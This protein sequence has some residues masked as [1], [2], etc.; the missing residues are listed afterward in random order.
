MN[1]KELFPLQVEQPEAKSL[2]NILS[3]YLR[4]WYLFAFGIAL[5]LG[6]AFAYLRYYAIPRYQ[7]T[8][9]VL[10]KDDD[11]GGTAMSSGAI[12]L[13]VFRSSKNLNNEIE[14]LKS[15]DLMHRVVKELDLGTTYYVE[16][17]FRN[18][19]L[20]NS[21]NPIRTIVS[22]LDTNI[23]NKDIYLV[24]KSNIEYQLFDNNDEQGITYRFGQ[25]IH[26]PYGSF[27]IVANNNTLLKEYLNKKIII[28]LHDTRDVAENFSSGLTVSPIKEDATVLRIGI[29]D[30]IPSRGV[31]IVNKLVQVYNKE[32]LE[33]R[34]I[35][36]TNTIAFLDD[37][38]KYITGEL[39]DV[40]KS[41]AQYK[42]S[43]ELTDVTTQA[44]NYVEQASDYNKRLSDW[45][46]QIDI[47]ESI[48]SYLKQNKGQYKMVP[49]TLGIQDETLLGLI[50]KFN[51][52]QLERERMLRTT[53]VDNPLVQNFNEQLNNLRANILENLGN[54]KRSL[55]ITS[56]SLKASS[57]QFK[58][59]IQRVPKVERELQEINRQQETKQKLYLFLLQRREEAA[60]SLAS[61]VSNSRIIDTATSTNYPI[62]PSKQIIYLTAL[63]LGAL[64]PF[65]ILYTKDLLNDKI[66]TQ[67][68]VERLTN[69]PILGELAHNSS[70]TLVVTRENKSALAEMFRLIRSNL[71]FAA[72]N[73]ENG[74]VILVTSSMSGEGKTFFT[75]N[76]GASLVLAGKRTLLIELDLR[77]PSLLF[78]LGEKVT[79]GLTD[80]IQSNEVR[81]QDIIRPINSIPDLDIIGAGTSLAANP[82][83]LMMSDKLQYL[84]SELK[85]MYDH[86]IID[87]APIGR[88]S[89]AFSLR[90]LVNQTIY[91]VRYNYTDKRQINII[92]NIFNNNLLPNPMIVLNDAKKSNEYGYG[93]GYGY[94]VKKKRTLLTK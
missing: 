6:V 19:E 3:Y 80:Y 82:A 60:I 35:T 56:N 5:A 69:T 18:D 55:V 72:G 21:G 39:S 83:E 76:L 4:Y 33:D 71:S 45:A 30:A 64:V 31:D 77:N 68:D 27:T 9:T 92:S 57:G 15:A 88:V 79:T 26:K 10:V 54:I 70:G 47:L 16:G 81:I 41:V 1:T 74:K 53:E 75:I 42:S 43:N 86:I 63:L 13:N 78:E 14:I 7:I 61:T 11:G 34:N 29:T 51:E 46:I 32:A 67:Q 37:R 73:A 23:V 48:E 2:K 94:E 84:I 24:A 93:H 22:K 52:L 25:L 8:S 66:R 20:Y 90:T 49:S 17:R 59:R 12:D 44:S 38:L 58:S 87:T 36:A 89:D 62:S 85:D 40:E 28:G 91:V 65:G 50:N